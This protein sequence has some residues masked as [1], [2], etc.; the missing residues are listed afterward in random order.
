MAQPNNITLCSFCGKSYGEVKKMV[1]GPGVRICDNC[2]KLCHSA[3]TGRPDNRTLCSFCGRTQAEVK[4]LIPGR[5]VYICEK[6]V[7][8]CKSVLDKEFAA[9]ARKKAAQE[10]PGLTDGKTNA[11]MS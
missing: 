10:I 1:A 8:L 5:G 2:I 3:L 11:I 9:D 4:M 7:V 6:C